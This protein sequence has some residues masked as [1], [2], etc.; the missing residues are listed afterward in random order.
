M[1][2]QRFEHF[3]LTVESVAVTIL[4][5]SVASKR[6]VDAPK[7]V[8]DHLLDRIDTIHFAWQEYRCY[9]GDKEHLVS[10]S[11]VPVYKYYHWINKINTQNKCT[12]AWVVMIQCSFPVV[13]CFRWTEMFQINFLFNQ[14]WILTPCSIVPDFVL[15]LKKLI[16]KFCPDA[17]LDSGWEMS[18]NK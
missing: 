8:K 17:I 18:V 16:E 7:M 2:N 13:I 1:W 10:P 3:C 5:V 14:I 12:D 11:T 9:F 4:S 15:N 6:C